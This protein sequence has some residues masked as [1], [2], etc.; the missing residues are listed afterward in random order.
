MYIAVKTNQGSPLKIKQQAR[1]EAER[2]VQRYY[3]SKM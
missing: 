1:Q 3:K 2:N